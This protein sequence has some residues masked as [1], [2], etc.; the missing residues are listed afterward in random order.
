MEETQQP[1]PDFQKGFNEG[2]TLARHLP[3]LAEQLAQ[4]AKDESARSAGFQAGRQQLILEKGR[5]RYPAW[6]K[7]EP[8]EGSHRLEPDKPKEKGIEPER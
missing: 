8:N 4:A 1:D 5:E 2:Y 3:E 6:L 7:G